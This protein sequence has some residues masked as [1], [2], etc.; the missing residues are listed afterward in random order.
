MYE[1]RG[2]A[3]GYS[4]RPVSVI[5]GPESGVEYPHDVDFSPDGRLL[6]VA[7]RRGRSL[8]CY[9]R[10]P[11]GAARFGSRPFW[12]IRGRWSRLRHPDGVKFVPPDAAYVAA[13]NLTENTVT[14]YRSRWL[15]RSHYASRACFVL[16]GPETGLREPD[17]LAFSDDGALLAVANHGSGTVT[18]YARGRRAPRYGP[19][20]IVEFGGAQSMLHCPH[21]VA[22]S[23]E[24]THLAI[25]NA[26]GRTVSV[27]RCGRGPDPGSSRWSESPV[28][29]IGAC[30]P[31]AF[32]ATNA[33]NRRE[34]GSKG[35]AFGT[36]CFGVCSPSIGLH[37]H[38]VSVGGS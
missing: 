3:F 28:L 7:N 16:A 5:E 26:G 18:V 2:E 35:V 20:P 17:G 32:S 8:T 4:D 34:G 13:A 11:G 38:R 12:T 14:F 6:V 37:V 15:H 33:R 27:Y 29:E 23:R 30:D 1:R 10:Q 25:S 19:A 22:F 24:G 9:A 36:D 21:S 31:V